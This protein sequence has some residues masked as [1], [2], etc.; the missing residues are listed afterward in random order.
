MVQAKSVSQEW[1][2]LELKN[3]KQIWA[4]SQVKLGLA[5]KT[6]VLL[7]SV[8]SDYMEVWELMLSKAIFPAFQMFS[9]ITYCSCSAGHPAPPAPRLLI[10]PTCLRKSAFCPT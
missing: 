2:M 1:L 3:R 5:I 7:A 8:V 4:A 6:R 9:R 10:E